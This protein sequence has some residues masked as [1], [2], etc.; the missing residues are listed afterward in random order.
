[1]KT[2]YDLVD[3]LVA[4]LVIAL[5]V[6]MFLTL[7]GCVTRAECHYD[8]GKLVCGGEGNVDRG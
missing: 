3:R 5:I 2:P 4:L 8:N 6:A 1:M 7:G